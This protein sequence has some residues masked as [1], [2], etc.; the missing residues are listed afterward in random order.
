MLD[1][2]KN[3]RDKNMAKK[4]IELL[5]GNPKTSFFFAFGLGHSIGNNSVIKILEDSGFEVRRIQPNDSLNHL[6]TLSKTHLGLILL[7]CFDLIENKIKII[8]PFFL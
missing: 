3:E 6:A 8:L 5:A 1:K 7:I 2:V 4:I